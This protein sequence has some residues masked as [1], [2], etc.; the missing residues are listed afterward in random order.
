MEQKV[1][2]SCF[3]RQFWTFYGTISVINKDTDNSR[4]CAIC[5]LQQGKTQGIF[6][7]TWRSKGLYGWTCNWMSSLLQTSL[8]GCC[9][10]CSGNQCRRYRRSSHQVTQCASSPPTQWY[11]ADSQYC[12]RSS[13]HCCKSVWKPGG[14]WSQPVENKTLWSEVRSTFMPL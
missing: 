13:K 2:A 8:R 1:I 7:Q 12:C 5:L 11:L 9:S 14:T 10:W 6:R 4:Q 3:T